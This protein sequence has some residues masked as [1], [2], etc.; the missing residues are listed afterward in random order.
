M[1]LLLDTHIILWTLDDNPKLSGY[2]RDLIMDAKNDIYFSAA[3]VWETT[4]KYMA[5]NTIL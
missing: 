4:I 5:K 3:S 1:K 2:A